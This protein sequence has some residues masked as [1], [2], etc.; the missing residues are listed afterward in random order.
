MPGCLIMDELLE[1]LLLEQTEG[2]VNGTFR[3]SNRFYVAGGEYSPEL[4]N[5][6]ESPHIAIAGATG[7]GKSTFIHQL[8]YTAFAFPNLFYYYDFKR[9]ELCEFRNMP[10][11]IGY[12][13]EPKDI[14]SSLDYLNRIMD[15]RYETMQRKGRKMSDETPI[16]IVIDEMAD[17]VQLGGKI[18]V[19]KVSRIARLGRAAR[20]HLLLA[21]QNPKR[22]TGLPSEVM[23]NM[24]CTIGMR[25][26]SGM[27][28]RMIVGMNGCELLPKHGKA[29]VY[30]R[31]D[32]YTMVLE[33]PYS[34]EK[35]NKRIGGV[36]R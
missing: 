24:T 17:L 3:K 23:Q 14:D 7:C 4:K 8:L 30:D 15:K 21:T 26:K 6:L 20:I 35:M 33:P 16:Y 36:T 10:N 19:G 27:E 29:I 31:G 28:S 9:V 13:T 22:T 18:A 2:C 12:T 11:C 25:C 1:D 34:D 5:I 32:L